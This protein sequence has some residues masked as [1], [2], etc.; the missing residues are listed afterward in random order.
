MKFFYG[1]CRVII[2]LVLL[3]SAATVITYASVEIYIAVY[4]WKYGLKRTDISSDYGLAFD[5]VLI[6]VS[7]FLVS[8]ILLL[9]L[10]KYFCKKT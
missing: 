3:F 10:R 8:T 1:I 9:I 6:S 4:L 7:V 5:V 2:N